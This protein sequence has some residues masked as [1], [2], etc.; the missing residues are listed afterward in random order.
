MTTVMCMNYSGSLH[1]GTR[2]YLMPTGDYSPVTWCTPKAVLTKLDI[3]KAAVTQLLSTHS[4]CTQCTSSYTIHTRLQMSSYKILEDVHTVTQTTHKP[5]QT[6]SYRIQRRPCRPFHTMHT[7]QG[8]HSTRR[9][10]QLHNVH[11]RLQTPGY[12]THT[13]GG[14]H[15]A[16]KCTQ[17][18]KHQLMDTGYA[19]HTRLKYCRVCSYTLHTGGGA[20]QP[21]NAHKVANTQQQNAHRR[22]TPN[23]T[24]HTGGCRG[25]ATKCTQKPATKCT[26]K[27][28]NTDKKCTQKVNTQ[29]QNAHSMRYTPSYKMHTRLQTARGLGY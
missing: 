21:H 16:T 10:A 13:G 1:I 14:A 22:C 28:A 11:R 8:R 9:Y 2:S 6:S 15:P 7:V 29:V 3:H 26:Q 4:S 5:L 27:A 23:Y 17:S 19:L 12:K 18:C 24:M 25:P 20:T